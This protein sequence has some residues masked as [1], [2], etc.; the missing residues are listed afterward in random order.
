[1]KELVNKFISSF[2]WL[3]IVYALWG[4]YNAYDEHAVEHERIL[5]QKPT[6]EAEI[7]ATKKK[8]EEIQDFIKK[9]DEYKVR[10]EEVAKNIENVQKQLPPDI[11]DSQILTYFSQEMSALNIK[12]PNLIP[13]SE[14][15]GT[16]FI[17]KDYRMKANGTYLQFLIFFERIGSA[18]RIYNVKSLKLTTIE[19]K[20]RGRFQL[21]AVEGIIQAFRYN[22]NFRVD[23]GFQETATPVTGQE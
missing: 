16:Y 7:T 11:N 21:L 5:A 20:K 23:R 12:D 14:L 19:D 4:A 17:S 15:S 10:V 8:V 6:I 1:M 18:A 2:H 22:P 3:I 13:D 9:T